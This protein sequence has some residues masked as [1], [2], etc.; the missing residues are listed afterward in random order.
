MTA[1]MDRIYKSTPK[2]MI[3]WNVEAPP[4]ELVE[5]VDSGKVKPCPTIDLGCGTGNYAIYL[6]TRGFDVTGVDLSPTAIEIAKENASKKG[7][8][9]R[10]I[11]A[12]ILGDMDEI[13]ETFDFAYD[14]EV[15]H[16]I[17]PEERKRYV[18]HVYSRLNGG[19]KY[20]SACFSEDDPEFGGSGK[21]VKTQLD[22]VLYLS[23]M[24]E[25]RDLFEPYFNIFEIKPLEMRSKFG[26]HAGIFVF[27]EKRS[28][29]KR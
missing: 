28:T 21:Y 13:K 29:C 7:V 6:A 14:W 10:F 27:M 20:L 12:D 1:D 25:L 11:V 3:P 5:L 4:E 23:S 22:T 17:F 15:L 26:T 2:E 18:E 24:D 9:C 19:G 16:H 8:K